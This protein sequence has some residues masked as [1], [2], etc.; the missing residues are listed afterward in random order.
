MRL[1]INWTLQL[2]AAFQAALK[3][4]FGFWLLPLLNLQA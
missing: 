4:L 2:S 1:F 3:V